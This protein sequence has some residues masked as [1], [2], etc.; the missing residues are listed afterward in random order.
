MSVFTS[1]MRIYTV[2][3]NTEKMMYEAEILEI[4]IESGAHQSNALNEILECD[5]VD[6]VDYSEDIALI[7][8]DQGKFKPGNPV[9]EIVVEDGYKL[10]LYGKIVFA[11]N[12]YNEDSVDL[13][14]LSLEEIEKLR[15]SLH[16]NL[17]GILK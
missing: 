5:G 11:R 8:D 1:Q 9:F 12:V 17:I 13:A 10:E 16:I 2:N 6:I 14:G 4:P 7:V 15:N 3:F